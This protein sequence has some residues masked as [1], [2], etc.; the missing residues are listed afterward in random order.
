MSTLRPATAKD[1]EQLSSWFRTVQE[2]REWGGPE[3]DF[4]CDAIAFARQCRLSDVN[5]WAL[6]DC[7]DNLL[8]FGQFRDR[9]GRCPLARIAIA[10]LHR[11]RGLG[12]H[13]VSS[14]L[15]T[16]M[17]HLQTTE[18]SLFVY[19]DNHRAYRLYR[20]LGFSLREWPTG[21]QPQP[22]VDYLVY[23]RAQPT[24]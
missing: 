6:P 20:Q 19:R 21:E 5:S 4:P 16:G 7:D 24:G 10:P 2:A 12:K 17:E 3:L 9:H 22:G 11:G 1:L 8:G 18:A 13:L 15:L 23:E 14:L